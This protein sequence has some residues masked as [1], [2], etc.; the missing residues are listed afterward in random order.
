MTDWVLAEV[1]AR[2]QDYEPEV[3][4]SVEA[5]LAARRIDPG[6]QRELEAEVL[7][8]LREEDAR[9]SAPL[10]WAFRIF[11]LA[12]P[13][14]IPQVVVGWYYLTRGYKRRFR[15]CWTWAGYGIVLGVVGGVAVVLLCR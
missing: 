15:E 12:F 7:A 2:Q 4:A 6:T 1:V 5:E 13:G 8:A 3:V 14:I 11:M 10:Q 9:A